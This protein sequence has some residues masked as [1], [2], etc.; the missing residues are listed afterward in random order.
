MAD[1][2]IGKGDDKPAAD[3]NEKEIECNCCDGE[4]C[5]LPQNE[6]TDD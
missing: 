1:S 6:W 2:D 4:E 3:H 5:R